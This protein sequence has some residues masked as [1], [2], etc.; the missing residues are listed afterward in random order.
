M[1][2][3]DLVFSVEVYNDGIVS[4]ITVNIVGTNKTCT[5]IIKLADVSWVQRLTNSWDLSYKFNQIS[6]VTFCCSCTF[7]NISIDLSYGKPEQNSLFVFGSETYVVSRVQVSW[8]GVVLQPVTHYYRACDVSTAHYLY[9]SLL[10]T[11]TYRRTWHEWRA[12]SNLSC[13]SIV[14][15]QADAWLMP[16]HFK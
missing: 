4:N 2:L 5:E 6:S 15:L 3:I 11:L 16:E 10:R 8:V 7:E 1:Y 14:Q 13:A 12:K 9:I